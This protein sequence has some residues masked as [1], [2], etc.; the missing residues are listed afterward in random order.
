MTLLTQNTKMKK[1]SGKVYN[2]TLPAF[3]ALDGSLTCPNAGKCLSGCYARQGAYIWGTVKAAHDTKFKL[4][5]TDSFVNDM[6]LDIFGKL[7]RLQDSETLF[8]RIHDAG[9][10]YSKEYTRKWFEIM[11]LF[12]GFNVKFYAYTKQIAMF[13]EL[14][15]EIPS[16]FRIVSSFGGKQDH[17][18]DTNSDAHAKVFETKEELDAAGYTDC[19]V[20]DLEIFGALK[21]GLIYHGTKSYKNTTWERKPIMSQRFIINEIN[22]G[23]QA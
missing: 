17:L 13:K 6:V 3:K 9:D 22:V 19:S 4:S 18:I 14:A 8:I 10:F 20:D 11:D 5:K 21:V 2:W 15:S 12:T 23:A 16:N 7:E 1:A